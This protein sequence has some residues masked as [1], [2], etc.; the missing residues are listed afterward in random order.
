MPDKQFK[1]TVASLDPDIQRNIVFLMAN[2]DKSVL[3]NFGNETY[4]KMLSKMQKPDM[5]KSMISLNHESL[6]IMTRELPEDL[7]SIVATQV[8]TKQF[9]KL[10]IDRCH[11]VLDKITSYANAST[12]S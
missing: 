2:E 10:M 8:D 9:A 7:F 11:D 6:Q 5:V 12:T 3:L 1:E 4:T